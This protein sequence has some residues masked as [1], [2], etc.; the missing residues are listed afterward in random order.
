VTVPAGAEDGNYVSR[1]RRP[2][3][4]PCGRPLR[5][6]PDPPAR[7]LRATRRGLVRACH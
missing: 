7:H 2:S 6:P 4:W 3:R 1:G 5:G